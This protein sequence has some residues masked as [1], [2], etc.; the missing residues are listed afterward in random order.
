MGLSLDKVTLAYFPAIVA[1]KRHYWER[2]YYDGT[3]HD[4]SDA[5]HPKRS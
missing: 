5:Q 3:E 2:A 4:S 1:P